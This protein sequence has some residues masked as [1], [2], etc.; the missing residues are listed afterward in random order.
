MV[1]LGLVIGFS[2]VDVRVGVNAE[3]V[4]SV[5]TVYCLAYPIALGNVV[6]LAVLVTKTLARS[7]DA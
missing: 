2:G 5:V 1:I 6:L 7:V 4:E 3:Y